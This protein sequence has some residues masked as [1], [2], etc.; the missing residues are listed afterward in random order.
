MMLNKGEAVIVGAWAVMV[1]YPFLPSPQRVWPL[2]SMSPRPMY[3]LPGPSMSPRWWP[4][5]EPYCPRMC[6]SPLWQLQVWGSGFCRKVGD[7][8]AGG[9]W[10]WST[11]GCQQGRGRK[12]LGG[13]KVWVPELKE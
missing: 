1:P 6:L 11:R 8:E 3:P 4:G 13:S 12:S 9:S 5:E 10:D 2:T 7:V